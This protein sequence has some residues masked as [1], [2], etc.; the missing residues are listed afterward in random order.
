M[1]RRLRVMR[2]IGGC[3]YACVLTL[4][5]LRKTLTICSDGKSSDSG[6]AVTPP[7][8][9]KPNANKVIS[10][11]VTKSRVSPRKNGAKN[12]KKLVDPFMEMDEAK[13]EEGANIFGKPESEEEDSDPSDAE[14]G[15]KKG[16]K[17]EEEVAI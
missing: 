9:P 14:F 8:T 15:P 6:Q 7:Q 5:R 3:T 10:G 16:I 12:Y 2:V 11:R 17:T 13:D 4:P 1:V